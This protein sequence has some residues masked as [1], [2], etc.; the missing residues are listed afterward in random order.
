[1]H[2]IQLTA[3]PHYTTICYTTKQ[4]STACKTPLLLCIVFINLQKNQYMQ[5]VY[6]AEEFARV[7]GAQIAMADTFANTKILRLCVGRI[8]LKGQTLHLHLLHGSLLAEHSIT[9]MIFQ[10]LI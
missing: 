5:L 7:Q 6:K 3:K 8:E 1:M 2:L 10:C 4:Y 9:I